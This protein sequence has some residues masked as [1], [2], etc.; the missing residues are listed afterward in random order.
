MLDRWRAD[1]AG[2][3]DATDPTVLAAASG[4]ADVARTSDPP[5]ARALRRLAWHLWLAQPLPLFV[6][7]TLRS[8]QRNS[9]LIEPSAVRRRERAVA[10]GIAIYGAQWPFPY[11]QR[12][13][14]GRG[15]TV[16]DLVELKGTSAA[17]A[18]RCRLDELEEF[19]PDNPSRSHYH[20][21]RHVVRL[22]ERPGNTTAWIYLRNPAD[23]SRPALSAA[24]RI[25]K[26]DWVSA[27][28]AHLGSVKP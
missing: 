12:A 22:L 5:S 27:R 19:D 16:G 24:M 8:G 18:V 21:V 3:E 2:Y 10:D 28:A 26:G 1:P 17:R 14:D 13:P 25:S 6:Y 9:A 23:T 7:G 4:L 20:R 11:A 15:C